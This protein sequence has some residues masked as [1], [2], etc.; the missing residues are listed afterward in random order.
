MKRYGFIKTLLGVCSGTDI[1]PEIVKFPLPRVL[2]HLL[3]VALLGSIINVSFRY[4]PF[5][6]SFESACS[7]LQQKFGEINYSEKGM[8]PTISPDKHQTVYLNDLRIDFF[9]RQD[10]L[11]EFTPD[12]DSILGIAWTPVSL[13]SWVYYDKKVSPLFPLLLPNAVN[14]EF[15]DSASFLMKRMQGSSEGTFSL[16]KVSSIY[17]LQPG[18]HDSAT[19]PFREFKTNILGIPCR[20]PTVY[21]IYLIFEMMLNCLIFSPV[22]ILIFTLFS[23]FLGKSN[24]LTL[25]F[26]ELF[27][28]GIY[29]GFPGFVIAIFYTAL[30]LPYLDFQSVFLIA[31]LFY[32]F[33]VF[34]RL[35]LD[36]GTHREN[37]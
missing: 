29:T 16:Y 36:Q 8:L 11:K 26:S 32:S 15:N 24:M 30:N 14:D 17:R 33:P 21:I 10:D 31:Y 4:H 13:V 22:Y 37:E 7:K 35:R 34:T 3:L 5:N 28:V 27:T 19:I 18:E 1:F 23:Y 6:L 25:K 9:P 20:I 2:W 12:N